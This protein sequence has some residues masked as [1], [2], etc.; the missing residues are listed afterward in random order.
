MSTTISDNHFTFSLPSLS[1]VDTSLDEPNSYADERSSRPHGFA[2]WL[3]SRVATFRARHA[4][5]VALGQLSQ[6]SDREL[7]DV[8]LNR[9]DFVRMFDDSL[10]QDLRAR[11]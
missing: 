4:Q 6:M 7:M 10:N 1:Y 5:R 2:E 11:G 3:A 9:G 8:G